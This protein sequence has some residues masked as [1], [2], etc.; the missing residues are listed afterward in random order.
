MNSIKEGLIEGAAALLKRK[1]TDQPRWGQKMQNCSLVKVE[2]LSLKLANLQP[3][4]VWFL[5]GCGRL[6]FCATPLYM[7][8]KMFIFSRCTNYIITTFWYSFW[9]PTWKNPSRFS[10][11]GSS[12]L[13]LG[14]LVK[15]NVCLEEAYYVYPSILS[16]MDYSV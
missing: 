15:L 11:P 9:F 5:R 16:K 4:K 2:N 12:L 14:Y 3:F 10:F 8:Q 7:K 1:P 13:C 6:N